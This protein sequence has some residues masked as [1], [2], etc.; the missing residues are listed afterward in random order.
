MIGKTRHP[1]AALADAPRGVLHTR[2]DEGVLEHARQAPAPLLADFVE[3]YWCV[4][5]DLRGRPPQLQE[6]LPHPN[7]HLIVEH[8]EARLWGV[9]GG[10]Y[11]RM[12]EGRETVFGVKFAAG[13][14]H[15]FL[16]SPVAALAN[17]SRPAREVFGAGIDAIAPAIPACPDIAAMVARVEPLLRATAPAHD[18]LAAQARALVAQVAGD[19]ELLRAEQLAERAGM[20]LRA[21]QRLFRDYVGASPK[22]V[23]ARYRLHEAVAQLQAGREQAWAELALALGY[24]DQAHFIRDFRRLV[25]CAPAD[26]ARREDPRRGAQTSSCM[27]G[28]DKVTAVP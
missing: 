20:G 28:C 2:F 26:Y 7:V 9:H 21:L 3:H 23:I 24:Y 16:R 10:R 12:L 19:R 4:R 8:G 25:G 6:T 14:F 15:A 27:P 13:G 18:P 17:R 11:R 5:W 22:W 1:S